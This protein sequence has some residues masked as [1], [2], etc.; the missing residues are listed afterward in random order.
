LCLPQTLFS[1]FI[2]KPSKTPIHFPIVFGQ[3]AMAALTS[4][5]AYKKMPLLLLSM[6][7]QP[8]VENANLFMFQD[9]K[10][11][12]SIFNGYYAKFP[13]SYAG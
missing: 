11:A 3:P 12:S 2:E 6:A 8:E 1:E 4:V 13:R 5:S 10:L 9:Y 7:N